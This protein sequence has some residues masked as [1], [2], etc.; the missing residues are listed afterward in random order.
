M[1]LPGVRVTLSPVVWSDI[2]GKGRNKRQGRAADEDTP[3]LALG[4]L[5]LSPKRRKKALGLPAVY[6]PPAL[7]P[8]EKVWRDRS[9]F[10]VKKGYQL[11][12]RYQHNWT[13]TK[14]GNG[15]H[16]HSGEDH[17]MQIVSC[18]ARHQH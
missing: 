16:H 18:S 1:S 9:D 8:S 3:N 10:L 11:R 15:R 4:L 5:E 7:S 2:D 13:P 6:Y 12:P 17:I 14:Y